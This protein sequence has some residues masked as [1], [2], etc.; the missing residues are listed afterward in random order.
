VFDSGVTYEDPETFG[1]YQLSY[2]TGDILSP[3]LETHE[4][5]AMELGD[6]VEGIRSGRGVNG[7][8]RLAR[9]VVALIEAA[10]SSMDE[11][12]AP[13]SVPSLITASA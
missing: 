10:E 9:D 5:L 13:I 4:P 3:K 6:F 2:R 1:Q 7:N 8:A 12:G 11:R